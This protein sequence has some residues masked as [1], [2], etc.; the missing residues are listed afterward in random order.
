MVDGILSR[1]RKSPL[2]SLLVATLVPSAFVACGGDEPA[3]SP[4]PGPS[5]SGTTTMMPSA[6]STP[7]T[8]S[9]PA[10][11]TAPA[12]PPEALRKVG[13]Q[14]DTGA[15]LLP[16]GRPITPTGLHT[17]VGGFPSDV[18]MHPSKPL[19]YVLNTGFV[20]RSVGVVD[21]ATGALVQ[22]LVR[23]NAFGSMA[24]SPDAKRLYVSGGATGLI[25]AYAIGADGKLSADAQVKLPPQSATV[26][27]YPAG[28]ALSTDGK[29]L[30]AGEF[31][32]KQVSI[33]DTQTMKKTGAIALPFGGYGVAYVPGR[34]ELYV[35]GFRDARVAVVD[36]ATAT[37]AAELELGKNPENLAVEPDGSR[38]YLTVPS[39]E[40]VYAIDP[41]T[42]MPAAMTLVGEPD[43][44]GE[45]ATPLP[46]SS[47]V[48]IAIGGGHVFVTR[49]QDDSVVVLDK[50]T[51]ALQGSFP[52]AWYPTAIGVSADGATLLVTNGKG[53]GAGSY[54]A[55]GQDPRDMHGSIEVVPFPLDLAAS[56]KQVETNIRRPSLVYPF[57]CKGTFPVP[58]KPNAKPGVDGPIK[59]VILVVK[60]NKTY[61]SVLGDMPEAGDVD[62][63]LTEWG[64]TVT[65]NLHALTKRFANHDNFY[66]DSET[67]AQ[68]HLWLTSS[69]INDYMERSWM[70]DY[71]GDGDFGLDPGFAEAENGFGSFFTH[72]IRHKVD[73]VDYGELTASL[74][75]VGDEGVLG[76]LDKHFPCVKWE[77][78]KC[79]DE[80]RANYV[81]DQIDAMGDAFY[82]FAF[83]I[84]PRDH[85]H[86]TSPGALTPEAMI[87]END[88][89][90]GV[91]LERLSHSSIWDS[92]AVFVVEDD[93]QN[94]LDHV[95]YH[96]SFALVA[97]PWVKRGYISHVH[98]S[99]PSIFRTMELILGLPPMNRFDAMATPMFDVFTSTKDASP[100]TR[101]PR[102]VPDALNPP[103]GIGAALSA[104][105][106]FSRPD[107]SPLLGDILRWRSTGRVR[108]GSLLD[109][110]LRGEVPA[111]AIG[112]WR[113][114]PGGDDDLRGPSC[115]EV[116]RRRAMS[117]PS[118]TIRATPDDFIVDELAAYEPSGAG[119]HLYVRFRKRGLDTL[120]VVRKL[121]AKL[122]VPARDAGVAG[123]KDRHAVTTQTASFPWPDNRAT[124]EPAALE[125]EGITVLE[126]ARHGNKLRTGHLHGNRFSLVLR[127]IDPARLGEVTR[128]LELAGRDGL[129]NWFGVQRFG[130]SG[131]NVEVALAWMRG[132]RPA[133]RDT[134]VRRLQLSAVQSALFHR[135]LER[136]VADG[137]WKTVLAGDLV[138]LR[139]TSKM[140]VCEDAAADAP[141]AETGDISATGPIFG[142]K[143]RWPEG[144][145]AVMER[146]I[147]ASIADAEALF[148]RWAVLGEGARRPLR[149]VPEALSVTPLSDEPGSLRV[150]FVLPKGAY[151]TSVLAVACEVRD[152]T[153]PAPPVR[154]DGARDEAPA[155]APDEEERE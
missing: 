56:S 83:M 139:N 33:V 132:E 97:S 76:H 95:D 140:F 16:G 17:V 153:R 105:I 50:A 30:Y 155:E 96:R 82:P 87:S 103:K 39:E 19:A 94:G 73:F 66:D 10:P 5:A 18:R 146:E 125:D 151:A 62:P 136:R 61:D 126:V 11:C 107:A 72:L 148:A 108:P 91:L 84:L 149:L 104:K 144:A 59:H 9:P 27:A 25:D 29:T 52:T 74:A 130:R 3:L 7:T 53:T 4:L 88:Y 28:L 115:G 38:V 127:E 45:N 122:G 71:R 102:G 6:S 2:V 85:T 93:P 13:V 150:Q 64:V 41:A 44:A 116:L 145:I 12:P 118:A 22:E 134:K 34:N 63:T 100:Y 24:L 128:A 67:S 55:Y 15:V 154:G 70:E 143:M 69:M 109:R 78:D 121:A 43:F 31:L 111:S 137:S 112:G 117:L 26:P 1:M 47:P 14:P 40:T 77:I 20:H 92:T 98:T 133:P 131:D 135:A 101:M 51:L 75:S 36:L 152:G 120:A 58:T 147:L 90:L 21:L 42:R 54:L 106:D 89:G 32:G 129:P 119:A 68:G 65:P 124:P 57:D 79:T 86:G 80:Q 8:S 23:D 48:G 138:A 114:G 110:H 123:L 46:G 141:R 60:E 142:A 37:V 113:G 49:A 99:Y 35:T 81:G